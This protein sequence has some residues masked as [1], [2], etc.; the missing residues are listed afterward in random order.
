MQPE[1]APGVRTLR[2][3]DAPLVAALPAAHPLAREPE[4]APADLAGLGLC[5]TARRSDPVLVD[6]VVGACRS[7][8]FEPLPGPVSGSR[9]DTLATIGAGST[10]LWTVV[11]AA[12]ARV[13]PSP[14]SPSVRSVHRARPCP[15]AWP[16]AA[17]IRLRSWTYS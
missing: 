2:L 6:P 4:P 1:P 17:G 16:S 10:P 7:A 9:Q 14:G 11:Y 5:L 8:G 12:H 15:S 3:W 13:L